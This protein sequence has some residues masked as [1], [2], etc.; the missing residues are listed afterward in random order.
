MDLTVWVTSGARF[1][2]PH[3]PFLQNDNDRPK[4]WTQAAW[5]ERFSFITAQPHTQHFSI[6]QYNFCIHHCGENERSYFYCNRTYEDKQK[7]F[8]TWGG[9]SRITNSTLQTTAVEFGANLHS[10]EAAAACQ[11]PPRGAP[12][13][14]TGFLRDKGVSLWVGLKPLHV[15]WADQ[16]LLMLC[17]KES[18][19]LTQE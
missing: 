17:G 13:T 10:A 6:T 4:S 1:P 11:V 19:T 18:H 2:F 8:L 3:K 16:C 12:A 15:N 7:G 9:T 14:R 5:K